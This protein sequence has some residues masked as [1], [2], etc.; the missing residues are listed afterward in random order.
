MRLDKEAVNT[1][2]NVFHQ[3]VMEF[4]AKK[5][6]CHTCHLADGGKQRGSDLF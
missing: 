6:K 1:F 5:G 4:F 2:C 3:C